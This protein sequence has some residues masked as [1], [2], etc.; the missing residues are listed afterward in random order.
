MPSQLDQILGSIDNTVFLKAVL[1]CCSGFDQVLHLSTAIDIKDLIKILIVLGGREIKLP[2]VGEFLSAVTLI[3]TAIDVES[4]KT[5]LKTL[6]PVFQT[7]VIQA[8][9]ILKEAK[10]EL[11]LLINRAADYDDQRELERI[12][13]DR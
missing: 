1:S 4:G 2:T 8:S 10:K 6:D 3:K 7:K 11:N 9:G 13:S 12:F 5:E